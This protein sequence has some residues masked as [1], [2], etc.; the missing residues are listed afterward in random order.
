MQ[1]MGYL[2]LDNDKIVNSYQVKTPN[3]QYKET[4][5]LFMINCIFL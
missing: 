4:A 2:M 3:Y 1:D 5:R